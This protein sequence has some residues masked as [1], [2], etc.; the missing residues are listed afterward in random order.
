MDADADRP[1]ATGDSSADATASDAADA[2]EARVEDDGAA[3]GGVE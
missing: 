2:S 3:D 1:D